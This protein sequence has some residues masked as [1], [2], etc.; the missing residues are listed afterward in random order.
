MVASLPIKEGTNKT[1]VVHLLIPSP[2]WEELNFLITQEHVV[3]MSLSKVCRDNLRLL[4]LEPSKGWR[5]KLPNCTEKLDVKPRTTMPEPD[6]SRG[7]G[8]AKLKLVSSTID[9]FKYSVYSIPLYFFMLKSIKIKNNFI[10]VK[11]N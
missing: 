9:I 11:I 1:I 6:L 8:S 4:P 10:W 2:A 3:C 5:K 7:L